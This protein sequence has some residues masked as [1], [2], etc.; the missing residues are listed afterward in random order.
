MKRILEVIIILPL[1]IVLIFL[2]VANRTPVN[3]SI[4]PF[5]PTA[6][7]YMISVPLFWVIFGALAVGVV[8]GGVAVWL[9]HARFR[10][11]ARQHRREAE[12]LR[13]E[14]ARARTPAASTAGPARPTPALPAPAA[15]T[16][17]TGQVAARS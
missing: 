13:N 14:V 7:D 8:L 9:R 16:G 6:A 11:A 5:D 2:A 1:A 12:R 15:R 3:L 17:A 4:N 10:R